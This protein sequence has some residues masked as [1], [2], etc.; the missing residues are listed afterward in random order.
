[1]HG[2]RTFL[3]RVTGWRSASAAC[4]VMLLAA[5]GVVSCQGGRGATLTAEEGAAL[6]VI[7]HS[8]GEPELRIRVRS[9]IT[10]ARLGGQKRLGVGPVGGATRSLPGPLV[11]A[12]GADGGVKVTDAVGGIYSFGPRQI[13]DIRGEGE[14]ASVTIDGNPYLGRLVVSARPTP[15]D[16][17]V[18]DIT[19]YAPIETYLPGV[20]VAEVLPDWTLQAFE[21]QAI[22]ARTY[23]LHQRELALAGGKDFDLRSDTRDQAYGGATRHVNALAGVRNTRGIVLTFR[24]KLLRAYYSSTCGGRF[25]G[26]AE[27]WPTG[28]GF[29]YNLAAPLQAH[30]RDFAC[31]PA[32]YYRWQVERPVE[33]LS[34]RVREWGRL[35]TAP[36]A[37]AL[38]QLVA[39][40]VAQR[41]E[42][43]RPTVYT[44]RDAAGRR[45][46]LSAEGL[47]LAC[48][49]SVGGLA[50]PQRGRSLVLSG[51]LEFDFEGS[52]VVIRGRGFG[53]GVGM[54][55]WC[56]EEMTKRG[57]TWRDLLP[58]FYPGATIERAY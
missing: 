49:Q 3:A 52:S 22:A 31:Q 35:N 46:Q 44:L 8:V 36:D 51:D 30:D 32:N 38:D 47:R 37:A 34:A 21:T 48:N 25:A 54:C 58:M 5:V 20:V 26:A 9:G 33:E 14:P 23:A 12:P 18:L 6:P 56:V 24:G 2:P 50:A 41:N 19:E 29:E 16:G 40:E 42:T 11:A 17:F 39:A 43:G 55:Q 7:E 10:E 4:L 13:V 45:A 15:K 1:M 57:R 53:H 28:P 27:V